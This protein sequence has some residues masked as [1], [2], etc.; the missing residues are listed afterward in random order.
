LDAKQEIEVAQ[1]V[2]IL[3]SLRDEVAGKV[4]VVWQDEP[5]LA[6]RRSLSARI[7]SS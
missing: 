7:N 4:K 2:G 6:S 3:G 5:Y 1:S